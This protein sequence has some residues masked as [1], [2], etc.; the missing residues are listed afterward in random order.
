MYTSMKFLVS[1]RKIY[2]HCFLTGFN[3]TVVATA[4]FRELSRTSTTGGNNIVE[5]FGNSATSF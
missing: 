5:G 3:L 4:D 2:L 1:E